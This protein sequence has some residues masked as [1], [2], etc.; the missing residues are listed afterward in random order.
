MKEEEREEQENDRDNSISLVF[1]PP[2]K[3][4]SLSQVAYKNAI[5]PL[6]RSLFNYQIY[7]SVKKIIFNC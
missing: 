2:L 5:F 4:L 3:S 6:Y 1:K 7:L